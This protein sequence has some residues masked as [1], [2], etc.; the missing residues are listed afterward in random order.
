[1]VA[2]G[3]GGEKGLKEDIEEK[4]KKDEMG[5]SPFVEGEGREISVSVVMFSCEG[6]RRWVRILAAAFNTPLYILLFHSITPFNCCAGFHTTLLTYHASIINQLIP[7]CF[8]FTFNSK[9]ANAL[10][11]SKFY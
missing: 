5:N 4:K 7:N 10:N 6:Q 9:D 3:G 11:T 2:V 1:M 8:I